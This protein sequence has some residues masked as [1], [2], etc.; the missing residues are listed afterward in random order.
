MATSLA[1]VDLNPNLYLRGVE[2]RPPVYSSVRPL[3]GGNNNIQIIPNLSGTTLE[4][5]AT[6]GDPRIG[7]Y[8]QHQLDALAVIA[9]IG[10]VVTLVHPRKTAQVYIL[11]FD[12][13]QLEVREPSGP[14]KKFSGSIILQEI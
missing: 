11:G 3:L 4:L 5:V 14:N 10:N 13:E 7:Q 2:D 9:E 6:P 12:T 1:G 8:C